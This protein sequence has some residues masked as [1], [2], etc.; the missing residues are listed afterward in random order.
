MP[1]SIDFGHTRGASGSVPEASAVAA[2][3]CVPRGDEPPA[4]ST[5]V[6]VT[7][8]R[9]TV[10]PPSP[11]AHHPPMETLF[12]LILIVALGLVA[13]VAGADTRGFDRGASI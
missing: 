5:N 11:G 3:T 12:V 8:P 10:P 4:A 2:G 9:T 7:S 13:Q 6:H 1:H